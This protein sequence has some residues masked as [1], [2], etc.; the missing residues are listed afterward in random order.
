[1][2]DHAEHGPSYYVKIWAI[3]MCL[4]VVSVVGPMAEIRWLTLITAFGIAVVKALMV[5]AYFMHLN[6][7]R[8]L[9]WYLLITMLLACAMFFAGTSP[10]S[11]RTEGKN[12]KNTSSLQL[13]E[14]HK[15][16]GAKSDNHE[17]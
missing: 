4:F 7:E 15:N 5:A 8:K 17:K 12:W 16:Y 9:V 6:V 3:L 11:M 10:D 2:S 13:I 1:M 14:E